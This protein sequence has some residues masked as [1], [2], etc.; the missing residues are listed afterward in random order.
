MSG[1]IQSSHGWSCVCWSPAHGSFVPCEDSHH[2]C[3]RNQTFEEFCLNK[4]MLPSAFFMFVLLDFSLI[5]P[6]GCLSFHGSCL[7]ALEWRFISRV[8]HSC[9]WCTYWSMLVAKLEA[10]IKITGWFFLTVPY[11]MKVSK[12]LGLSWWRWRTSSFS[13]SF[14][15]FC[16]TVSTKG[17]LQVVSS[18]IMMEQHRPLFWGY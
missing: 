6:V 5:L 1:C 14:G 11:T 7:C 4:V 15:I 8:V 2:P 3:N 18:Q 12:S 9:L 17:L 10:K 13:C 16:V